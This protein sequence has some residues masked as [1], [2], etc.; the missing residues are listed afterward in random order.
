MEGLGITALVNI[1]GVKDD[2]GMVTIPN[3]EKVTMEGISDFLKGKIRP[4]KM[5]K[6]KDHKQRFMAGK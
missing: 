4:L 3:C 1:S 6:D 2:L 5:N